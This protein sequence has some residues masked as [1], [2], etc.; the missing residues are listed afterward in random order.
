MQ[1][2]LHSTHCSFNIL[3]DRFPALYFTLNG[4]FFF[5]FFF[6]LAFEKGRWGVRIS[7]LTGRYRCRKGSI[8]PPGLVPSSWEGNLLC[9]YTISEARRP[10]AAK[11]QLTVV[12]SAPA[13]GSYFLTENVHGQRYKLQQQ[14]QLG[15][16]R[17]NCILE[18][19]GGLLEIG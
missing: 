12:Y 15:E 8:F 4:S 9:R 10:L 18:A 3:Q 1:L 13:A 2:N 11:N 5:I 6:N 19:D 17:F 7:F 16:I 14:Q